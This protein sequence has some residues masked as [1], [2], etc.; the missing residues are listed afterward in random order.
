[1]K[2]Y[3]VKNKLQMEGLKFSKKMKGDKFFSVPMTCFHFSRGAS[4]NLL[5][6]V[7]F[8]NVMIC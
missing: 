3:C 6:K 2:N 5:L 1:M 4:E 8:D 7:T